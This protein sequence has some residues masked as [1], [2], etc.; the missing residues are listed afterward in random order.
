LEN[1]KKV[2]SIAMIQSRTD[3]IVAT[4]VLERGETVSALVN[5]EK[6]KNNAIPTIDADA[7]VVES[8]STTPSKIEPYTINT[9]SL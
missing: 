3:I 1:A 9:N 6:Y 5:Y 8:D 4:H 7:A 2:K